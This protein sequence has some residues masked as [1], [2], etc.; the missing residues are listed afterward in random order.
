MSF[1]LKRFILGAAVGLIATSAHA[2]RVRVELNIQNLAATF[3][4]QNANGQYGI[5]GAQVDCTMKLESDDGNEEADCSQSTA[6]SEGATL[7]V[8]KA[9]AK[10]VELVMTSKDAEGKVSNEIIRG[11][12]VA[13][14]QQEGLRMSKY[15]M[16][17]NDLKRKFT[18]SVQ[19]QGTS[20]KASVRF[21]GDGEILVSEDGTEIRLRFPTIIL[22][23]EGKAS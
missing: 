15:K 3:Q 5:T 23:I 16:D 11:K 22:V 14:G 6:V 21:L 18:M 10:R 2:E 4:S 1:S 13:I 7:V 19:E 20:M 17:L 9:D 8:K 12:F